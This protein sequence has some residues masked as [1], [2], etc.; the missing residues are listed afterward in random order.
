MQLDASTSEVRHCGLS[1]RS[2]PSSVGHFPSYA[3][4]APSGD[5]LD[6]ARRT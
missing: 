6:L 5:L 2:L 4:V 3:V 1:F